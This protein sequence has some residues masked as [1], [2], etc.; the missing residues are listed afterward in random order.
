MLGIFKSKLWVFMNF[1]HITY[2]LNKLVQPRAYSK[3]E[4]CSMK[5]IILEQKSLPLFGVLNLGANCRQ[6]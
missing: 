6:R 4:I 2:A 1:I 3:K 5:A